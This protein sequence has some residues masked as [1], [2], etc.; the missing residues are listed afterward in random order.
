M[1]TAYARRR[2]EQLRCGGNSTGADTTEALRRWA[3][4]RHAEAFS[5]MAHNQRRL[6]LD[7]GAVAAC[8]N[9]GERRLKPRKTWAKNWLFVG[10]L[11][12]GLRVALVMSLVAQT[13]KLNGL[14]R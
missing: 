3:R 9:P 13:A 11:P 10:G 14:D 1:C 4:I 12:A 2:F 6:G 5:E 7:G 8:N